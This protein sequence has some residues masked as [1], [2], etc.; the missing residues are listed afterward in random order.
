MSRLRG[1]RRATVLER[2]LYI[3]YVEMLFE[4]AVK[5]WYRHEMG[6]KGQVGNCVFPNDVAGAS[7]LLILTMRKHNARTSHSVM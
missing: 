1:I 6:K 3:K 5:G 7:Y 4:E 2:C